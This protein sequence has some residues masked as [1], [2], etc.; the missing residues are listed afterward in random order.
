M[1]EKI[2]RPKRPTITVSMPEGGA[3]PAPAKEPEEETTPT[4]AISSPAPEP[5]AP[6]PPAAPIPTI[7][8]VEGY[9]RP[10]CPR[11]GSTAVG[12]AGGM[13]VCNQCGNAWA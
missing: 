5:P 8:R 2:V 11:C 13:R 1:A 12:V 4:P 3:A 10:T 6:K 9:T 7:T